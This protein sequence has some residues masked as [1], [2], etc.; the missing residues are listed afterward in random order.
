MTKLLLKIV[1]FITGIAV[2]IMVLSLLPLDTF[3]FRH[4]ESMTWGLGMNKFTI[5]RFYPDKY[6]VRNE[7][8]DLGHNSKYNQVKKN[9]VW[10]T[11]K[12]GFRNNNYEIDCDIVLVGD[13]NS[14]GCGT[15][16]K[17]I[18]SNQISRKT[19]CSVFNYSPMKIDNKFL[20]N[21]AGMGI[22]PK[23]II[24]QIIERDIPK[25]EDINLDLNGEHP[26]KRKMINIIREHLK[27]SILTDLQIAIDRAYKKEPINFIQGKIDSAFGDFNM[28][29][30]VG[31][32][33]IL[34][35]DKSFFSK[36]IDSEEV[37]AIADKIDKIKTTLRIEGIEFIFV[38]VPN[39]ESIYYELLPKERL[40]LKG[41][42]FLTE[43]KQ[44]LDARGVKS[45][46]TYSHFR[47]AFLI[48]ERVYFPDDTHW[49]TPG[50][51]LTA[52]LIAKEIRKISPAIQ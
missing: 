5:G 34:F 37:K 7:G 52:D 16:Q 25:L 24:Y 26:P 45:I 49:N 20:N 48:G 43:L 50:I 29:V 35:Y 10:K 3:T 40:P 41:K 28:P 31:A 9:V 18:L 38:P 23:L 13:S 46:D 21:L 12:Y 17:M 36:Q 14:V 19:S 1:L 15:T 30:I 39:K 32:E 8:G 6:S 44:Q 2:F 51:E 4:W 11:D 42:N 27:I 47:S 22:H 33:N